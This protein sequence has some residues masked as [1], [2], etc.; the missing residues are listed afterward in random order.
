LTVNQGTTYGGTPAQ[1]E[2]HAA[3]L[4]AA[5]DLRGQLSA[6]KRLGLGADSTTVEAVRGLIFRSHG[7]R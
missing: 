6:L 7:W 3:V 4:A 5:S 2:L 1:R